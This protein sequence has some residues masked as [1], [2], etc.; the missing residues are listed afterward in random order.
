MLV[1]LLIAPCLWLCTLEITQQKTPNP[2]LIPSLHKLLILIASL[3]LLPLLFSAHGGAQFANIVTPTPR[4]QA[5]FIHACMLVCIAIFTLQTPMFFV[6]IRT[7]LLEHERQIENR[8]S[9]IQEH[10]LRALNWFL[11]VLAIKWLM[12][13]LRTLHCMYVGPV[14]GLGINLFMTIEVVFT[15]RA[16]YALSRLKPEPQIAA[17]IATDEIPI[18]TEKYANSP[19]DDAIR[20]RILAKLQKAMEQE[21]L[22][23]QASFSLKQLSDHLRESPHYVSQVIN[24]DLKTNFYEWVNHYR[25]NTAKQDLLSNPNK[26]IITIAEDAGFNSKSTFNTAFRQQVQMTPSEY[27]R[28]NLTL[29]HD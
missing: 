11:W 25:I 20:K 27:R 18:T 13:I 21:A 26:S 12:V 3:C 29:V 9:N 15:L 8:F 17:N 4:S 19:L 23:K 6:Q 5:L 24:Q 14:G 7:L 1:S 16:L 10:S 22:Y 2:R 28:Q